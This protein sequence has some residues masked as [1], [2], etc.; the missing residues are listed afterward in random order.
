MPKY[1]LTE[2]QKQRKKEYMK[3][4]REKNKETINKKKLEKLICECG[5]TIT[6]SNISTH[7]KSKK[8]IRAHPT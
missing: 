5:A 6:R 3:E 7:K 4:Y 1:I 8:H 2:E